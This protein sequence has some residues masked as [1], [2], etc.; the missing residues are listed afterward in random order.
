MK[1]KV[2]EEVKKLSYNKFYDFIDFQNI[3]KRIIKNNSKKM[4][5]DPKIWWTNELSQLYKEKCEMRKKFNRLSNNNNLINMNRI[6]AKFKRQKKIEL[7]NRMNNIRDLISPQTGSAE[8]WK[9]IRSLRGLHDNGSRNTIITEDL[10]LAKRVMTANFQNSQ[11]RELLNPTAEDTE[12]ELITLKMFKAIVKERKDN[13]A[14]GEDKITYSMLKNL[15][16]D[17][18]DKLVHYINKIYKRGYLEEELKI[19]KSIAIGK[20]GKKLDTAEG[21]RLIALYQTLTKIINKAVLIK[22]NNHIE[23]NNLIPETSF[24]F[25][26]KF[27]NNNMPHVCDKS[28]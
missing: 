11:P 9:V 6:E 24:G 20:P 4:E 1:N 26:K 17:V 23:N 21:Y 27:I 2:N 14:P 25:K 3:M 5:Y 19:I 22:I 18:I 28:N 12:T 16:D 15:N 8:A 10:D 7:L 13:S